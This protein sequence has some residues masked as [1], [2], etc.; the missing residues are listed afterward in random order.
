MLQSNFG[1]YKGIIVSIAL[2]L[3]LDASVLILNFYVSF[4]IADD[5]Q[6]VNLAGRQR[7]LSQRMVKSLLELD[8]ALATAPSGG[9]FTAVEKA[10]AELQLTEGL[11]DE[12]LKAF[13]RGGPARGAD[14]QAVNLEAV[15]ELAGRTALEGAAKLWEPYKRNINALLATIQQQDRAGIDTV[16]P[17][18]IAYAQANNLQLL[19][20]MNNLTVALEG[21][22]TSK[23]TRLRMIQ[24]VGISLAV[25]NFLI[26]MFHFLKQLRESDRRI[27]A[28]RKETTDILSTVNEGLFLLDDRLIIGT[29]YSDH[30]VEI[31]GKAEIAGSSF[32]QLLQDM[33]SEKD[34]A[35]AQG[36][37]QLLFDERVKEKLIG[38][39]NPLSGIEVNIAND[40]GG[41][42]TK[43]LNFDFSRV[44]LDE[45]I[46][47]VLVT[48]RDV[49]ESV[50]LAREL[51]ASKARGEQQLEMLTGILHADTEVLHRFID[52][53]FTCFNKI[54][55]L[56]KQPAKA[57][58]SLREKV[59]TL[60]V[61]IHKFK[62][63]AASLRLESFE[64]EAHE[65]E[66]AIVNLRNKQNLAGNDFL[67]LAVRL[68][69]LIGYTQS[70]QQLAE[71][72]AE[73][74]RGSATGTNPVRLPASRSSQWQHLHDLAETVASRQGKEVMLVTTG[75]EEAVL[76][77]VTRR[78]LNDICIQFIR[79]AIVHGVETPDV[80]Q[81]NKKAR[82]GRVDVRLAK[83]KSGELE[84]SVRDDGRGFDY[85]AI[86]ERAR[87]MNRWSEAE[88]D[89]LDNRR[90][91]S[92]I[93]EPGFSTASH[94]G[95]DAGHGVGMD[96]VMRQ[97]QEVQ[98][99][100]RLGGSR[101]Q[102]CSFVVTLPGTVKTSVA[103]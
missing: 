32:E 85:G 52:E 101:G 4:E 3:L 93:F 64:A 19:K 94:A 51:E 81:L 98:G 10:R 87:R 1:K 71:K 68:D 20:L 59:N 88:L 97:V 62:G 73:L 24:T 11:F 31:L 29:Q 40:G 65:F 28:A 17:P 18:T 26:I 57:S 42:T 100:I 25:I 55:H 72:L 16:L 60:F 49:T 66:I 5:A 58:H 95:T 14:G 8:H 44:T 13:T 99:R 38:D 77:D 70:I 21:V 56:L 78:L 50:R 23:A 39:L 12:T 53:A 63:E 33:I 27:E 9:E 46:Q 74:G 22:A 54:N 103:A 48:V 91:L 6:G 83:L 69:K 84:L 41:Y 75:L 61:E 92:L 45:T 35:T 90:L 76:P 15:Q 80:R 47:H 89:A 86:R 30:L 34:L 7:M 102:Y 67:G 37:V 43:H 96:I 79:N 36:F 82:C 2:F